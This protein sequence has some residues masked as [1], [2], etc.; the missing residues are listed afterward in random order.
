MWS[1]KEKLTDEWRHWRPVLPSPGQIFSTRPAENSATNK[2]V[3]TDNTYSNRLTMLYVTNIFPPKCTEKWS[4]F[5]RWKYFFLRYR[6]F[7][8]SLC[9]KKNYKKVFPSLFMANLI[10]KCGCSDFSSRHEPFKSGGQ[11]VVW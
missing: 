5:Y 10:K 11:K 9:G 3:G 4:K 7:K 1:T 2:N 6:Y 8:I